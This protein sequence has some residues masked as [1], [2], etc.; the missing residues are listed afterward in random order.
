MGGGK[1]Q[2]IVRM[3]TDWVRVLEAVHAP[4]KDDGAWGEAIVES[5]RPLLPRATAIGMY[6]ISQMTVRAS[7]P[8]PDARA[9]ALPEG[10]GAP[11]Q[12]TPR[13]SSVVWMT[14]MAAPM[15]Y[16][17]T[18]RNANVDFP[19]MGR[20]AFDAFH[21]PT[22]PVSTAFEIERNL[23]PESAL[24]VRAYRVR[25]G[26]PDALGIVVHPEPGLSTVIWAVH[27]RPIALGAYERRLLTRIALHVETG[28]RLR[29]RPEAIKAELTSDG[30]VLTQADAPLPERALEAHAARIESARARAARVTGE[31]VE[32]WPALLAGRLSVVPRGAGRSRRYAV[33]EN[34][35]MTHKLHALSDTENDV[36]SLSSRGLSTK[37][38]AYGL[39]LTSSTVSQRLA[40]AASKIG[41]SSRGELVRL[42]AILAQDGRVD[43]PDAPLTEAE[44]DVLSLL[45]RGLSNREIA[46]TRERS[47]RTVA[48]QVASLLRKTGSSSRRALVASRDKGE[49]APDVHGA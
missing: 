40:S 30:R 18:I 22:Y 25:E 46:V 43:L 47:V 42:A 2:G 17:S 10:A 23:D 7:P 35:P 32:L 31:A 3:R 44:R 6:S 13:E 16:A 19:S 14:T 38:V 41:V 34:P 28:H 15:Q 27:A 26:I 5:I 39:G 24:A 20:T 48:N 37:L 8:R 21:S 36:L 45:R 11:A 29:L 12:P 4:A 1:S 9:I 33:I 49:R